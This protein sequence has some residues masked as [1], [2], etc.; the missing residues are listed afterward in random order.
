[1]GKNYRKILP[2][3]KILKLYTTSKCSSIFFCFVLYL[4]K[5]EFPIL[6]SDITVIPC[7]GLCWHLL[8]HFICNHMT[9]IEIIYSY[10]Y[11]VS[12]LK[13][14]FL[15]FVFSICSRKAVKVLISLHKISNFELW[16]PTLILKCL[17]EF[18]CAHV[19]LCAH[20][21]MCICVCAFGCMSVGGGERNFI[22]SHLPV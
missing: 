7:S 15:C 8:L 20:R 19:C 2:A 6:L 12:S 17:M 13:H 11:I 9:Y 5:S 10:F 16:R 1:M 4:L 21:W 3:T 22:F 14:N 18:A